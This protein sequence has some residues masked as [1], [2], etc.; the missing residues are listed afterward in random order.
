[1]AVVAVLYGFHFDHKCKELRSKWG[2]GAL[3]HLLLRQILAVTFSCTN[4]Q[5]PPYPQ[6]LNE[7]LYSFGNFEYLKTKGDKRQFC[8]F[9][10]SE[11][12]HCTVL[13]CLTLVNSHA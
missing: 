2:E 9:V 12:D 10:T 13:P 4:S 6:G 3:I 5:E 11:C 8:L 7:L 1:M